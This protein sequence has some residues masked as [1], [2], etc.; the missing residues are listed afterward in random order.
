MLEKVYPQIRQDILK[1]G[2]LDPKTADL[3]IENCIGVLPVPLGLGL[4]FR[5]N[6]KDYSVPMAIEEPS[7][8]AACSSIAKIIA[9][10]ADG[11]RA[12]S[13]RNVMIGQ[14]QVR[15]V[16]YQNAKFLIKNNEQEIIRLG[17]L[18]CQSM[19][20]RGGGVIGVRER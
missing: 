3:M 20:K 2:G 13:T 4:N 17:N 8:V 14:I 6:H 9:K 19:V 16:D 5:I 11:F 18:H 12:V 7:V 15:D 1:T 10:K